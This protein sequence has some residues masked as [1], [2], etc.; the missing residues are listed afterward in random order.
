MSRQPTKTDRIGKT[1]KVI[2]A[3]ISDNSQG[4]LNYG[5]CYSTLMLSLATSVNWQWPIIPS[6]I[7]HFVERLW[8]LRSRTV[9]QPAYSP[10]AVFGANDKWRLPFS[11]IHIISQCINTYLKWIII[12]RT[13]NQSSVTRLAK[14]R[15]QHDSMR[16]KKRKSRSHGMKPS[17]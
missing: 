5:F 17:L 6:M 7:I 1:V 4:A 16:K 8:T 10:R 11:N 2:W 13:L 15:S 9:G 12:G 14:I 3:I